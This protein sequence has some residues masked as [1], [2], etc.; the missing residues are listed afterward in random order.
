M[1]LLLNPTDKAQ[2]E[3]L[4][5]FRGILSESQLDALIKMGKN[6]LD[7]VAPLARV[8]SQLELDT[9]LP[10]I[11]NELGLTIHKAMQPLSHVITRD[12]FM[13]AFAK[14]SEGNF[15]A[16]Y[17]VMEEKADLLGEELYNKLLG[18]MKSAQ[19]FEEWQNR[20]VREK[21]LLSAAMILQLVGRETLY[22]L[23][24]RTALGAMLFGM[25]EDWKVE[26]IPPLVNSF[27]KYMTAIEDVFAGQS[28]SAEA[29]EE[30]V[31]FVLV[32]QSLG[33]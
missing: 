7:L 29:D 3:Y 14:V 9:L 19:A 22:V 2:S 30:T 27:D 23:T 6:A 8:R 1:T 25:P 33:L 12:D 18:A 17:T 16:L 4:D 31:P 10:A 28:I 13:N 32:K 26:A 11:A 5:A 24:L 15:E 21:N 20:K